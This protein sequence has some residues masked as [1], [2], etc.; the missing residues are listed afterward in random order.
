MTTA[1]SHVPVPARWPGS[2]QAATHHDTGNQEN[3]C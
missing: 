2:E 1:S 3:P